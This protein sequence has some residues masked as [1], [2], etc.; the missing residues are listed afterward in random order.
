MIE[1]IKG[2]LLEKNLHHIVVETGGLGYGMDISLGTYETLPESG[3]QCNL[4]AYQYIREDSYKL[5]GFATREE[6]E[7][8]EALIATSGIGPKISLAI[9]SHMPIDDFVQSI[10]TK[11]ISRLIE[12]PSIGKKTAERLCLEL[13]DRLKSIVI[14]SDRKDKNRNR[15]ITPSPAHPVEDAI[16]ALIALGVKPIHAGTAIH[17]AALVLGENAS[18]EDLIKEGLKYR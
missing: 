16:T 17:K 2:I 5:Y 4:Y 1:Y 18:V 7:I 11:D 14:Q 8:F 3:E 9:L 13:K 6:R 12:I 10:I 15:D